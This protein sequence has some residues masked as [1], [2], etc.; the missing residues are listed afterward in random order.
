MTALSGKALT[1]GPTRSPARG[2][3]QEAELSPA[4]RGRSAPIGRARKYSGDAQRWTARSCS[5]MYGPARRTQSAR[6]DDL[7]LNGK[8]PPFAELTQ[9]LHDGFVLDLFGRAAVFANHELALMRMLDIAAGDKRARCL[10]L[11]N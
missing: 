6:L 7:P 3:L 1:T 8:A 9:A 5:P 4:F 2:D 11:V 10:D